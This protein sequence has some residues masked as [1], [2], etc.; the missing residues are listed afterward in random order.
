M[1]ASDNDWFRL[2]ELY[3]DLSEQEFLAA[4]ENLGRY[5]LVA[6]DVAGA[7][8]AEA[9]VDIPPSIPTLKERSSS[10]LKDQS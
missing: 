8:L 4:K 6:W 10:N 2:K 9:T 5:L 7:I 3:P 1:Q